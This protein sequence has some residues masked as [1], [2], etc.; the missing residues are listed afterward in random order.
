MNDPDRDSLQ[1]RALLDAVEADILKATDAEIREDIL[2]GGEDSEEIARH[3]RAIVE[4]AVAAHRK[5]KLRAAR[6]AYDTASARRTD[7]HIPDEPQARRSLLERLIASGVQLP[8]GLTLA[9]REGKDMSD[10]DVETIL[11]DLAA[12]GLLEDKKK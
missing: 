12:L 9:F 11:E 10:S 8:Q 2:A 4:G 3:M 7:A 6:A 5:Q 1:L